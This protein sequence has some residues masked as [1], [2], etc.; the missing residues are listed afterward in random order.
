MTRVGVR[1]S[2]VAVG[3]ERTERHRAEHVFNEIELGAPRRLPQR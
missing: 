1:D 2:F 3:R